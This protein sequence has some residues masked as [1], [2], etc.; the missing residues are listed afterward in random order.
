MHEGKEGVA[1][2]LYHASSMIVEH[3]DVSHSREHLD[4]G[5]GFYLTLLPEQACKYA[6]RF[7]A[8]GRAAF[9]NEY[10]LDDDL[11]AYRVKKFSRYDGEWLDYV[12]SC[13]KGL[14]VNE[15]DMVEGGIANDRVFNTIDLYFA[16]LMSRDDALGRLAFEQPNHQ[17]CI[18]NQE[19]LNSHLHFV[20]AKEIR[21][22][23]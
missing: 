21:R 20:C 14:R 11:S 6:A 13:R 19:I 18:L 1:M 3:P 23:I 12:G 10:L 9:V 8:R 22:D 17:L 16:G 5:K 4:F 2:R 15:Y 7:L